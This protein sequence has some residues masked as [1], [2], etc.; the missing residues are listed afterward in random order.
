MAAL[1]TKIIITDENEKFTNVAEI[2]FDPGET[3]EYLSI[4]VMNGHD[5][6]KTMVCLDKNDAIMLKKWLESTIILMD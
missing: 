6:R 5:S 4:D 2:S 1:E 3:E